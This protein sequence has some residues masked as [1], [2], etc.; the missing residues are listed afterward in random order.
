MTKI[1]CK[2]LKK[3]IMRLITIDDFS[4]IYFKMKQ[5]GFNFI[6]SKLNLSGRI[7]TKRTHNQQNVLISE[8]HIISQVNKR[9]NK[10][11][12]SSEDID[13]NEYLMTGVFA[14]KF[15]LRL[16]SLG[17]GASNR[18]I[19][20]ASHPNFS[21]I[22]CVDIAHNQLDKA[23][24]IALKNNLSNIHFVCA[25]IAEYLKDKKDN[26]D[27]VLFNQSLHHFKN[28]DFLISHQIFSALKNGGNLVIN[29]YVGKNQLQYSSKQIR[30]INEALKLIPDKY[31]KIF[32]TNITKKKFHGLGLL[33]MMIADPSECID[34][35]SILPSI[36]KSFKTVTE[37][38]YGG[39]IIMGVLKN[40]AHNF[41]TSDSDMEKEQV[42]DALFAFEDDYLKKNQSD[43]V[44]GIYE[45]TT[46]NI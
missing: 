23:K 13:Y 35:E 42:L 24:E 45:K 34:S 30:A 37:K 1:L 22:I 3:T 36:H 27:I 2:K 9:R 41:L 7:R 8:W 32:G 11:I 43:F 6:L 18:E 4:D 20:L 19:R 46:Q 21:E 33:R 5:R 29:E 31:K 10:L 38:P 40:I 12:T 28:V 25:D 39:N 26:F 44:F 16:L 15:N 14:R 17:S